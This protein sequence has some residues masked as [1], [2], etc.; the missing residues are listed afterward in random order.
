M[1][2]FPL[3]SVKVFSN[4]YFPNRLVKVRRTTTCRFAHL[5][6]F[7]TN[8]LT[9]RDASLTC[10]HGSLSTVFREQGV[11]DGVYEMMR[12]HYPDLIELWASPKL[13][14][15]VDINKGTPSGAQ[16]TNANRPKISR[17]H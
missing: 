6:I 9:V 2:H 8:Y 12:D 14:V 11:G 1:Q 10:R 13:Q 16:P 7:G 17:F 3:L 5:G 15:E 4:T